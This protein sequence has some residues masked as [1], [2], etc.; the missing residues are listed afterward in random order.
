MKS[1]TGEIDLVETQSPSFIAKATKM[2]DD[3]GDSA[4]KR[5]NLFTC[6]LYNYEIQN[7]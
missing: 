1:L 7:Q 2:M 4:E 5:G 3:A 6:K